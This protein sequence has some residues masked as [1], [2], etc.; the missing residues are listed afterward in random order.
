MNNPVKNGL[1]YAQT[2]FAQLTTRE[3]RLVT[4]AGSAVAVFLVFILLYSFSSSAQ[5]YRNRTETKLEK[6][7]EVQT[8]AASYRDAEQRRQAVERQLGAMGGVPLMSYL[9]EKGDAA[10]L[11]IRSINPKNDLPIGDGKIIESAVVLTLADV[12]LD[13]LVQFLTE[14][15]RGPGVVKVKELRLEPRRDQET[16]TAWATIATYSMKR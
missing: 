4:L 13:R 7:A 1:T 3:K 5:R 16:I 15:E 12:S 11:D 9:E 6:L 14:V 10:G 2:W 8:L